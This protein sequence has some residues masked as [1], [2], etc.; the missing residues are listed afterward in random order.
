MLYKNPWSKV[1][2]G[3]IFLGSEDGKDYYCFKSL[4]SMISIEVGI[5]LSDE[6]N[7]YR[8]LCWM[9]EDQAFLGTSDEE[10]KTAEKFMRL[11]GVI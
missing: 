8:S 7:D 1:L 3:F 9:I 10:K 11:K 2:D 5:R 6:F 4:P